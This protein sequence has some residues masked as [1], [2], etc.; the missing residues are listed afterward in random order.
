MVGQAIEHRRQPADFPSPQLDR[1]PAPEFVIER[2]L[3]VD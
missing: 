3:L 1:V 2:L